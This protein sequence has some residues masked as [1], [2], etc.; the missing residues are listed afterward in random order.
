MLIAFD[1]STAVASVALYAE[2]GL[3]AETTWQA[4]RDQTAHLLPVA[5]KMLELQKIGPDKLTG[6]AVALGPGSFNGLRVGVSAAKGMS[7]ALNIPIFGYSS[8]NVLAYQHSYLNGLLCTIVEAGRG[9]LGV[10][11]YRVKAG[12]WKQTGEFINLTVPELI[13]RVTQPTF[14][15]GE[16]TFEQRR[17]LSEGLGK[18]ATILPPAASLRRAGSLAEMAWER[19]ESF[20]PGDDLANLQP[21]YLHQPLNK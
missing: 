21:I 16:L 2:T 12:S 8:L 17:Q 1:T 6:V 18:N 5:Q 11:F 3:I 4:H 10:G 13:E 7:L 9:R 14:F 19:L 20:D 15:C